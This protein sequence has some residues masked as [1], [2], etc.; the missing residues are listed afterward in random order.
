[1][2][3]NIPKKYEAVVKVK[4]DPFNE[5]WDYAYIELHEDIVAE[6]GWDENTLLKSTVKMGKYGNVLVVG[7]D[8]DEKV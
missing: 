8:N 4:K 7:V 6:L 2:P 3:T 1:M 5:L